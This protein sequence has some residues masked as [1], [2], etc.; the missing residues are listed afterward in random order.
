MGTVVNV[1][2]LKPWVKGPRRIRMKYLVTFTKRYYKIK[3]LFRLI[4]PNETIDM[5]MHDIL[6]KI[7]KRSP[8]LV[9]TLNLFLIL[10]TLV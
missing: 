6:T 7:L 8:E 9:L 2:C 3:Y 1:N 5:I 4:I 10:Y